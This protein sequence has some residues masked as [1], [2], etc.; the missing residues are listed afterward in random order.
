MDGSDD[1]V[2]IECEGGT[3]KDNNDAHLHVPGTPTETFQKRKNRSRSPSRHKDVNNM[4]HSASNASI[5]SAL[6]KN[7]IEDL[8][9][10]E[11]ESEWQEN[12]KGTHL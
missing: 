4:R 9:D 11:S 1:Y 7:D 12:N 8:S 3:W 5:D 10:S 2:D 6:G